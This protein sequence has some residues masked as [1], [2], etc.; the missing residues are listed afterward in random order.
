MYLKKYDLKG[1]LAVVTGGSQG[2]GF[3]CVEALI[4][5]GAKVVLTDVNDEAVA[6]GCEK[7]ADKGEAVSGHTMDVTDTSAV[8][9][10]AEKLRSD[11]NPADILICNA[12]IAQAGLPV[13]EMDDAAWHRMID[14]NLTGVFRCCRAFGKVMLEKG[15]GTIVNIGSMSGDIVNL[16]QEQA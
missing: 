10:L 15:N 7:L 9:G 13:E 5:A 12:G 2:I 8:H 16:P 6:R 3:A 4:E 1:R 11:G 14:I